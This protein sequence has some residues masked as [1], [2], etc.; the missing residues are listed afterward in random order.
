MRTRSTGT[1]A[2]LVAACLSACSSGSGTPA[3]PSTGST[4]TGSTST[5]SA[6]TGSTSQVAQIIPAGVGLR[7][8]TDP[9]ADGRIWVLAGNKNVKNLGHYDLR[10]GKQLA[11]APVGAAATSIA[12]SASGVIGVGSATKRGGAVEFLN[13]TTGA[14]LSSIRIAGA[15]FDMAAGDDGTTFYALFSQRGGATLAVIDS[16]TRVVEDTV[17]VVAN[18]VA[19]VPTHDE[20]NVYVLSRTGT[21]DEVS[22]TKPGRPYAEFTLPTAGVDLALSASG[23]TLYVL[24]GPPSSRSISVVDLATESQVSAAS[25]AAHS[26]AITAGPADDEVYDFVGTPKIGNVQLIKLNGG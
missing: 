19:V 4:S 12:A 9:A 7:G 8:G 16:R 1:L 22:A 5:G 26:V 24:G 3:T 14:P 18:A 15:V 23:K 25:A 10:S 13:T 21:I 2:V 11:L 17:P 6:S 20:R